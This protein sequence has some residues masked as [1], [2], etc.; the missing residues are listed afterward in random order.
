MKRL[1]W[2]LLTGRTPGRSQPATISPMPPNGGYSAP[3]SPARPGACLQLRLRGQVRLVPWL[4]AVGASIPEERTQG[5]SCQWRSPAPCSRAHSAGSLSS[6]AGQRQKS[7]CA[8]P[9]QGG[10][11]TPCRGAQQRQH[12]APDLVREQKTQGRKPG[13]RDS[14]ASS[15]TCCVIWAS[16]Y[17]FP[18]LSF[19]ICGR[20]VLDPF[21]F[22]NKHNQVAFPHPTL[23]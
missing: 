10:G 1:V 21:R 12:S 5:E 8:P 9:S 3:V 14:R 13:R 2:F 6:A 17:P 16:P 18:G 19:L 23:C 15:Q 22:K 7:V 4:E 11:H 20:N